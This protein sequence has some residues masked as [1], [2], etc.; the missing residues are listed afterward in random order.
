MTELSLDDLIG[1]AEEVDGDFLPAKV[2]EMAGVEKEKL[3][4]VA[5]YL[6]AYAMTRMRLG[7]L[8]IPT[9]QAVLKILDFP[10]EEV[11]RLA[12]KYS[13]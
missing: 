8:D 9:G 3:E 11:A 12:K 4:D 2:I 5:Y 10:V 13:E 7:K 1:I 6:L